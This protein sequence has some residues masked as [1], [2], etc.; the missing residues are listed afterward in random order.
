MA[1]GFPVTYNPHIFDVRT[2]AEAKRVI[3]TPEGQ[4]SDER[5]RRETPL[6]MDLISGGCDLNENSWVLDYGVGIGR[7]AKALID[8]YD[9][10]VVGVDISPSMRALAANYVSSPRFFACSPHMLPWLGIR[11]DLGLAIWTLQHCLNPAEDIA[12]M[13][14]VLVDLTKPP[15]DREKHKLFVVNNK[16]RCMP[17]VA[18]GWANDG[19][20]VQQML[21]DAG[22][23]RFNGGALD[24]TI[25]DPKLSDLSM[26]TECIT[27]KRSLMFRSPWWNPIRTKV[28]I[29]DPNGV[30]VDRIEASARSHGCDGGHSP[31][32]HPM[33]FLVLCGVFMGPL[34]CYAILAVCGIISWR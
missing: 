13:R 32:D 10:R 15:D 19:L 16:T 12:I 8:R 33:L 5:W 34:I 9:C 21:A 6:L 18:H 4:S 11:Y 14:S 24:P 29:E 23:H 30:S 7:I 28:V 3:L 26:D 22:A 2:T 20:D 31:L 17:T 1:T 27:T 25:I